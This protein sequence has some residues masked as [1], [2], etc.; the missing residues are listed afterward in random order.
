MHPPTPQF[1]K[2]KPNKLSNKA[3]IKSKTSHRSQARALRRNLSS[4]SWC[5]SRTIQSQKISNHSIRCNKTAHQVVSWWVKFSIRIRSVATSNSVQITQHQIFLFS[6]RELALWLKSDSRLYQ[7]LPKIHGRR[8]SRIRKIFHLLS[9]RTKTYR[10]INLSHHLATI[11]SAWVNLQSRRRRNKSRR[12]RS[13]R[14]N[15]F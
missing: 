10:L 15:K 9:G 8:A 6:G 12:T 11:G 13:H 3:R 2:L 1:V 4:T 5:N 7:W 14:N